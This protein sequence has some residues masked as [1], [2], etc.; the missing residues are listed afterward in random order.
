MARASC[1]DSGS[2]FSGGVL[3]ASQLTLEAEPERRRQLVLSGLKSL[4]RPAMFHSTLT[5][6]I[7]FIATAI[8][9]GDDEL[10]RACVALSCP[11][12]AVPLWEHAADIG[13]EVAGARSGAE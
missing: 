13:A 1:D 6:L 12:E 5:S 4:A 3:V 11:G 9:L 2:A 7:A 10:L 8:E